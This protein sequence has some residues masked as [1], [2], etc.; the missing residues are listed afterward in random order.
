MITKMLPE[1]KVLCESGRGMSDHECALE[2]QQELFGFDPAGVTD[3]GAVCADD[4]VTGND[5]GKRIRCI[6][7]ADGLKTLA[8]TDPAGKLLIGDRGSVGNLAQFL[9][10][11]NLERS[12]DEVDGAGEACEL[13]V[14]IAVEL[15]DHF[16]VARLVVRHIMVGEVIVEP[17][18]EIP[19]R[20]LRYTDLAHPFVGRRDVDQSD[21]G[22][23]RGTV[24]DG[25]GLP[26]NG[27]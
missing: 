7:P 23:E 4:T 16:L 11:P 22:I 14:E 18:E 20:L 21:P 27:A 17:P 10:D 15:V 8:R 12:A 2:L 26:E 6:R 5:D 9:P 1:G 13:S 25:H 24:D 19:P 3:E